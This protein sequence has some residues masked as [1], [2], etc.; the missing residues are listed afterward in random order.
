MVLLEKSC[1][2]RHSLKHCPFP[3]EEIVVKHLFFSIG[4]VVVEVE[5]LEAHLLV[6]PRHYGS[7]L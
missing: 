2:P 6:V 3:L 1:K 5:R 4:A 7:R